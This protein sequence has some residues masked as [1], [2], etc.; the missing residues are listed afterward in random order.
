VDGDTPEQQDV[1]GPGNII[2]NAVRA[3]RNCGMQSIELQSLL[4]CHVPKLATKYSFPCFA[5]SLA[6]TIS[7]PSFANNHSLLFLLSL[8]V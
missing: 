5:P 4:H 8:D 2:Y 3:Y 6:C 7:I 1:L